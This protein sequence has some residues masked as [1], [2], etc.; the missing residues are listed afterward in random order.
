MVSTQLN[1]NAMSKRISYMLFLVLVNLLMS[2]DAM[3]H[4]SYSV[5]NK[6]S[7][8]IQVFIPNYSEDHFSLY[9]LDARRD[10]T[11]VLQPKEKMVIGGASKID[12]PWGAKNIYREYPG[13]CGV[14]MV[15]QDTMIELGCSKSEWKYHRQNTNLK[16]K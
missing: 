16:I 13:I 12:F 10:T 5:E 8:P 11:M 4:L 2:C 7:E 6:T 14:K 1:E 9:T 3:V 15:K